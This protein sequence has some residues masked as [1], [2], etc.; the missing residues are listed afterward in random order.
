MPSCTSMAMD[1]PWIIG[2]SQGTRGDPLVTLEK[3]SMSE[4]KGLTLSH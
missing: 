4:H 2:H 1:T 3:E